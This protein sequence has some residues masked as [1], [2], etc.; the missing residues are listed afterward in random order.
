MELNGNFKEQTL[1]SEKESECFEY[2]VRAQ[3]VPSASRTDVHFAKDSIFGD[4]FVKGPYLKDN[5]I[6]HHGKFYLWKKQNDILIADYY[7]VRL[8]PDVFPGG[9]PLG[10]RNKCD[11]NKKYTFMITKSLLE[12]EDKDWPKTRIHS[13]KL[14]PDT[15]ILETDKTW[16]PEKMWDSSK[17]SVKFDFVVAMIYRAMIGAV[18]LADKNFVLKGDRLYSIDE[19]NEDIEFVKLFHDKSAWKRYG[20]KKFEMIWD[21]MGLNFD[22]FHD[23]IKNWSP[24]IVN[25]IDLTK[26]IKNYFDE[27]KE[28]RVSGWENHKKE[29]CMKESLAAKADGDGEAKTLTIGHRGTKSKHGHDHDVLISAIHKYIRRG[30]TKKLVYVFSQFMG[31]ME[32][33]ETTQRKAKITNFANRL[34]ISSVEDTS[35]AFHLFEDVARVY[36]YIK[37]F[38]TDLKTKTPGRIWNDEEKKNA[39]KIFADICIKICKSKRARIPSGMSNASYLLDTDNQNIKTDFMKIAKELKGKNYE[40]EF[41][42]SFEKKSMECVILYKKLYDD[43]NKCVLGKPFIKSMCEKLKL[44]YMIWEKVFFESVKDKKEEFMIGAVLLFKYLFG[45]DTELIKIDQKEMNE[46]ISVFLS[47]ESQN[48]DEYVFDKHT[49]KGAK[50]GAGMEKFVKEGSVVTNHSEK[51]IALELRRCYEEV[52]LLRE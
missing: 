34:V 1:N 46:M 38:N 52:R 7:F 2:I 26:P 25:K 49:S 10:C 32:A 50:N 37:S 5:S 12:R 44:N 19:D 39:A 14:W 15:K 48:L 30:E 27:L 17:D 51:E 47:D 20:Y 33:E 3:L 23:F 22:R 31:Y 40:E 11:R 43:G 29:I 13:S 28:I 8:F 35:T 9:T 21:Y 42:K 41:K 16:V 24:L 4:C 36:F 18:D 45:D 6:R